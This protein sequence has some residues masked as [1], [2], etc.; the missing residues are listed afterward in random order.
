MITPVVGHVPCDLDQQRRLVEARADAAARRARK[1]KGARR[2]NSTRG[3]ADP[4]LVPRGED[5]WRALR[6]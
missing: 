2:R 6:F 4:D 3:H 5:V 1:R